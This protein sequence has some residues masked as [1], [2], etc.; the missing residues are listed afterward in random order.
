M[1][2]QLPALGTLH[3]TVPF[4]AAV[5][6]VTLLGF[7]G[8]PTD[9]SFATTFV[10]TAVTYAVVV[11]SGF[12]TGVFPFTVMLTVAVSHSVSFGTGSHTS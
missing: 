12:A 10:V 5:V 4:V 3:T 2:V 11:T 8:A 7:S 9:T 6:T 1:Y